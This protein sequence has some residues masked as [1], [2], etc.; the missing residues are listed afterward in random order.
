MEFPDKIKINDLCESLEAEATDEKNKLNEEQFIKL[1][2]SSFDIYDWPPDIK[3]QLQVSLE[4]Q[5]NTATIT[6][7][8]EVKNYLKEVKKLLKKKKKN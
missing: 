2:K 4:E 7:L 8:K 3:Q 5:I 1:L 6:N